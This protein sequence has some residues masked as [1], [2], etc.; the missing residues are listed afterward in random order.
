MTSLQNQIATLLE[1]TDPDVR[2]LVNKVLE[3]EQEFLHL[4]RPH[5][6]MEKIND[7]LNRIAQASIEKEEQS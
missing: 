1:G 5:G 3:I 6:V 7:I 4:E 2:E